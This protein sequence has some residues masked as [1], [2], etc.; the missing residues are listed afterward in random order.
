MGRVIDNKKQL[1][2]EERESSDIAPRLYKLAKVGHIKIYIIPDFDFKWK[3]LANSPTKLLFLL[4]YLSTF[5]QEYWIKVVLVFIEITL[6][7][8]IS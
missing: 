1:S 7:E 6:Y 8:F 4:F 5:C 3:L 2:E